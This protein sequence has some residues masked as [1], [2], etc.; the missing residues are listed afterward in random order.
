MPRCGRKAQITGPQSVSIQLNVRSTSLCQRR[1]RSGRPEAVPPDDR[2]PTSTRSPT[3]QMEEF[4]VRSIGDT[5]V[6]E[7][8]R[9]VLVSRTSRRPADVTVTSRLGNPTAYPA[10]YP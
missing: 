3:V 4:P 8:T 2:V 7:V 1:A 9:P 5:T 6:V 10:G